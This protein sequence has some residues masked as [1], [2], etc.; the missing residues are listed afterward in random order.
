MIPVSLR[1]LIKIPDHALLQLVQNFHGG[2]GV[3]QYRFWGN[4]LNVLE[5]FRRNK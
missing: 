1:K 2:K 4:G 5:G 3:F